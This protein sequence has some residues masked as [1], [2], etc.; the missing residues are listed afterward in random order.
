MKEQSSMHEKNVQLAY[1]RPSAKSICL[2]IY[3]SWEATIWH[4]PWSLCWQ[5]TKF[6]SQSLRFVVF[7]VVTIATCPIHSSSPVNL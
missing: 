2:H 3:V 1:K 4:N 6:W 5:Y 7:A